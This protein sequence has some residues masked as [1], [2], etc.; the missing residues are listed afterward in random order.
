M[1]KVKGKRSPMSGK[2]HIYSLDIRSEVFEEWANGN[3]L[4]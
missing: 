3:L 4:A 2:R 1:M